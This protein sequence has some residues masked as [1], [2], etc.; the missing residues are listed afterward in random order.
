MFKLII[1]DID[2]TLVNAYPAIIAS[3]NYAMRASG[4]PRKSAYVIRRAVG[5]GDAELLKP[6]VAEADLERV[7]AVYREHHHAALIE[8]S[9]LYPGVDRMLASFRK[10]G[11][12]LAVASNRPTRFSELLLAHVGIRKYFAVVL[13]K[14][15]VRHGK[16]HPEILNKIMRSCGVSASETLYV[17]DMVI[18][19]Q[20]AARAGVRAVMV[21]TGSSTR[22]ELKREKPYKIIDQVR[23]LRGIVRWSE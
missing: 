3:F 18:D 13:C 23:R 12:T 21:T 11:I 20:A 19:A 6:F 9:R 4:Y 22:A 8:K 17:G 7:L 15:A 14:D 16:P 1:F 5:R 2:G 10:R